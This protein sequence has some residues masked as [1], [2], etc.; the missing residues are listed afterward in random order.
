[1]RRPHLRFTVQSLMLRTF[2]TALLG[3]RYTRSVR[4]QVAPLEAGNPPLIRLDVIVLDAETGQPVPGAT[5]DQPFLHPAWRGGPGMK[6]GDL[7]KQHGPPGWRPSPFRTD[8]R[9]RAGTA[10]KASWKR[11]IE[12]RV[13]GLVPV[14][15]QREVTFHPVHGVRIEADGFES[16]VKFL[17]DIAPED[18]RR[19]DNLSTLPITVRLKPIEH[20][21]FPDSIRTP[22]F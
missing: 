15:G 22:A 17:S 5:V 13:H 14:V 7:R 21:V 8:G 11:R 2:A 10:V 12:H 3:W 16:W 18:G 4:Q 6:V 20:R 1:M 19:L 9:G